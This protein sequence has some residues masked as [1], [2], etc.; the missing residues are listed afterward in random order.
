MD[1]LP[2]RMAEGNMLD[3]KFAVAV[4]DLGE[5]QIVLAQVQHSHPQRSLR[6]MGHAYGWGFQ[7]QP[8]SK[9]VRRGEPI[10][11]AYAIVILS[12]AGFVASVIIVL[13]RDFLHQ[14]QG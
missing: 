14:R 5:L 8:P 3:Q 11:K 4:Q 6:K 2:Q 1:A 7:R 10:Y 9:V 12:T 13:G